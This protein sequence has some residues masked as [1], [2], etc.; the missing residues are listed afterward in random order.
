MLFQVASGS[1]WNRVSSPSYFC[2]ECSISRIGVKKLVLPWRND[3]YVLESSFFDIPLVL[4]QF[5]LGIV[6][7]QSKEYTIA[8]EAFLPL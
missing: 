8:L 6:A 2:L 4:L 1:L 3:V 5:L 7:G